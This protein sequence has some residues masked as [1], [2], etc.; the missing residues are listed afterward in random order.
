[1]AT[2]KKVN[3]RIQQKHDDVANWAKSTNFIT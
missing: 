2:E 1:M 3:L